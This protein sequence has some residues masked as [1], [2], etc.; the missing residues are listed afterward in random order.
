MSSSRPRDPE[1]TRF[2]RALASLRQRARREPGVWH[3]SAVP[4]HG[5]RVGWRVDAPAGEAGAGSERV[6]IDRDLIRPY[7]EDLLAVLR[8]LP[9]ECEVAAAEPHVGE[10]RVLLSLRP[11]TGAGAGDRCTRC[12]KL[13]GPRF[14]MIGS[15]PICLL[16]ATGA[17]G[18]DAVH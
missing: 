10:R 9:A 8:Y 18:G 1:R 3:E 17:G 16:C 15:P 2:A 13:A 14:P 5:I 6:R 11:A 4:R 12:G 7:S